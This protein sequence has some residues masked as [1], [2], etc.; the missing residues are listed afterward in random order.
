MIEN[1]YFNYYIDLIME[2]YHLPLV[3]LIFKLRVKTTKLV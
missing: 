3:N 1:N 2:I